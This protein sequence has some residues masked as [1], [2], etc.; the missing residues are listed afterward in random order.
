MPFLSGRR[1][2]ERGIR[3]WLG[4]VGA[5]AAVAMMVGATVGW[6]PLAAGPEAGRAAGPAAAS[7]GQG[8]SSGGPTGATPGA[9]PMDVRVDASA[10]AMRV[11]EGAPGRADRGRV[12]LGQNP[13]TSPASSGIG[14]GPSGEA[15]AATPGPPGQA[16]LGAPPDGGTQPLDGL[17]PQRQ[18]CFPAPVPGDL[19]RWGCHAPGA[20]GVN[21]HGNG[22]EGAAA[23]WAQWR[24]GCPPPLSGTL[25]LLGNRIRLRVGVATTIGI[26]WTQA[27]MDTGAAA[28]TMPNSFMEAAGAVPAGTGRIA[29]VVPGAQSATYRYPL[30]DAS[31]VVQEPDGQIVPLGRDGG[32]IAVTGQV[33]GTWHLVG[34][35]VLR[36]G[37]ALTVQGPQWV[38]QPACR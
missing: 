14:A 17:E 20:G 37:A 24:D 36:E 15:V 22:F 12:P 33:G 18:D 32:S 9:G 19:Q 38:L 25:A 23:A 13:V 28:T 3:P 29:G 7:A 26:T 35:D 16:A 4:V 1:R 34:P 10:G 2:G 30:P 5:A 27:I 31:L 6:G 11:I 21:V 8:G